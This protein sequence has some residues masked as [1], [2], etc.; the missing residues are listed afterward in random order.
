MN[1]RREAKHTR[2]ASVEQTLVRTLAVHACA[3]N[4][5]ILASAFVPE[6]SSD[7]VALAAQEGRR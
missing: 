4:L 5:H 7:W 2:A 3:M 6:V 1:P